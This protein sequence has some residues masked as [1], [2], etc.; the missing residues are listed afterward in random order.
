MG[1]VYKR[2]FCGTPSLCL[3]YSVLGLVW[4][5][6]EICSIILTVFFVYLF[7]FFLIAVKYM[8]EAI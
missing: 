1:E 6:L 7:W 3:V 2:F 5:C 4:V 8:A